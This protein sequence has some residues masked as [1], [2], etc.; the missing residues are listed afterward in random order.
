MSVFLLICA[1][2]FALLSWRSFVLEQEA[3]L[4]MQD[5]LCHEI[6]G[7][8]LSAVKKLLKAGANPNSPNRLGLY[9]IFCAAENDDSGEIIRAL[10]E[11]GVNI[12]SRDKHGWTPLIFAVDVAIDSANQS[13]RK[14]IDWKVVGVLLDLGASPE[15]A[16]SNG[17]TFFDLVSEYGPDA[18]ESLDD[19]LKKRQGG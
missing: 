14:M 15:L 9:P 10:V 18:R 17:K 13:K 11:A 1:V 3:S 12:N 16:E 6:H 4:P 5:R 8:N 7:R 19:F 2:I